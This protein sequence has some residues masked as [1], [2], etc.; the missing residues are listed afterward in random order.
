MR[1]RRDLETGKEISDGISQTSIA[2]RGTSDQSTKVV[3]N[4]LA[5]ERA[6]IENGEGYEES[7]D[8]I[9]GSLGDEILGE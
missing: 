6:Q 5:T 3:T 2:S 8:S 7:V 4:S 1:R 9:F